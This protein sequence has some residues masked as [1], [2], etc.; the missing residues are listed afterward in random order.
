MNLKK[1]LS[2]LISA[3]VFFTIYTSTVSA[4]SEIS[5]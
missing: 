5:E 2:I 1:V 3:V 4:N